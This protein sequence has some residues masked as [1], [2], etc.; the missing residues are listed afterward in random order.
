MLI[1][2]SYYRALDPKELKRQ[3][4][5]PPLGALYAATLLRTAGYAPTF[6][7]AMLSPGPAD[8]LQRL[9]HTRPPLLIIYDDEFNYLTK[10]CLANM[11]AATLQV[12]AKARELGIPVLVS[13]SDATDHSL[14][15]LQAGA[16]AVLVGEAEQTLRECVE[17]LTTGHWATRRAQIAGVRFLDGDQVVNTPPRAMLRDLDALPDPDYGFVD[18]AAYQAIWRQAHGYFSLNLST[19]RGCPYH[20]N[21]CAKPIYGQ[22][23][24]VR[25]P[26]R[27]AE[28]IQRLQTQYQVD[29]LW[30]TDD[31][32]GLK[33]GWL[34]EFGAECARLGVRVPYKC[35][36]RA[37]LLLRDEAL[38][39]L[40]QSGCRTIWM[41]AESGSQ[42]VLDAMEKGTTVEQIYAATTQAQQLGLEVA[43]FLQFGYPGETWADIALTRRMVRDCLPDDIGISVSYPLPGTKFYERVKASL[44][45]KTHWDDSDDLA[46]MYPGAYPPAFYRV[47]HRFVHAE[48]RLARWGRRRAVAQLPRALWQVAQ[49]LY[50]W[51]RL[52]PYLIS[53]SPALVAER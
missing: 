23:Y 30:M 2:Q 53:R 11:R 42:K 19:T 16:L 43:F 27:V 15:Y 34:R 21:W 4:P 22:V 33:P 20:C 17:A 48:Y 18:L 38:V 6:Y 41:G 40:Q 39:A 26:R 7:D 50:H 12:L 52:Q 14:P 25:S 28:E 1:T 35:L 5:Y 8:F 31:I 45:P 29:H 36:S 49:W 10:M 51:V 24:H 37:D 9:S 3:M 44:G 32:F 47:L 13:S 46:L